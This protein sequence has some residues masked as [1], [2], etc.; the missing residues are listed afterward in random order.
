MDVEVNGA[1]RRVQ[2]TTAETM[3]PLVA[4]VGPKNAPGAET[5][6]PGVTVNRFGKGSAIYC[7][8]P[9]FGAYQQSGAPAL[10]ELAAELLERVYPVGRRS[11]HL[12]GAPRS[13]EAMYMACGPA[14]MVHLVSR[15]PEFNE[16]DGIRVR[17]QVPSRPK[18]LTAIP[19]GEA[20]P[21]EWKSGGIEFPATVAMHSAY[22]IEL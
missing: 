12:M 11:I 16:I 7:A 17:A 1:Y 6:G 13:I 21:F 20:V 3:I 22:M 5:D 10:R 14:R 15:A 18:R 4:A 9:L 2:A 19:R 8:A